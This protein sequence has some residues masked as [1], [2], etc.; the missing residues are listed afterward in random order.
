[1]SNYPPGVTGREYQIA[2]PDHDYEE[3]RTCEKCGERCEHYVEQY[4]GCEWATCTECGHT[5]EPVEI[6]GPDGPDDREQL[7]AERGY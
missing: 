7:R 3:D 5:T 6:D 4:E 1:V 2:G